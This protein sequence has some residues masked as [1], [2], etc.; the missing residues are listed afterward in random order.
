MHILAASH[1]MGLFQMGE[2]FAHNEAESHIFRQCIQDAARQIA[3][4]TQHLRYFLLKHDERRKEVHAFLNKAEAVY[5]YE[6]EKDTPFR[7]A[8]IILL[9]GGTSPEQLKEGMQKLEYCNRRW[10]NQ[11]VER[12]ASAGIDRRERLQPALR[13]YVAEPE[14]EPAEAA[15]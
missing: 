15:A 10:V 5:V 7:E 14:A 6:E 1:L 11:Y 8:Q 12:L 9:G 2:Y 3:Y 13:K 4:G